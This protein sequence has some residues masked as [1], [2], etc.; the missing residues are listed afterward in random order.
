VTRR[1]LI[2]DD[3]QSIR[4]TLLGHCRRR[5]IEAVAAD[6]AEAALIEIRN[7]EP[8]LVLTDVR[9]ANMDGLA[10][11]GMLRERVPE[12]DVVIMT[13]FEDMPTAVA[14]MKAG[15]LEYLVKPLDLD[16][17]DLV[18]DR[19]FRDRSLRRR[20]EHLTAEAARP[21]TLSS[22]VGRDPA[23][24]EIY[25]RIGT[26]TRSRASVLIRGE[27][28]TGK[29]VIARAIHFNSEDADEPFVAVNCTAVPEGLLES[30]LFGH[31]RGAFTGATADRRGRFE[32]AG[33]GTI[34]LD[35]I[36]DTSLQFQSKLL[37]VLQEREFFAVG[38][39]RPRRTEARV[40][41]ATHR[42]LEGLVRDGRFREDLYY[43]LRVVEISIPPLRER[44]GDIADLAWHLLARAA[45]DLHRDASLSSEA[46]E[47]LVDH[48]WP[49]NV[50]E[51]ENTIVR[52]LAL[53]RGTVIT[54]DDLGLPAPPRGGVP[55]AP[56]GFERSLA[57]V[58]REHILRVLE[59]CGNNKRRACKVLG[60]SRPRLDRLL[61]R[62]EIESGSRDT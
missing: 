34:F 54:E 46:I 38:S 29:E 26:V 6:S 20:M 7:V 36:G 55:P 16:V 45:K 56:S 22:L 57:A 14:A 4:E 18:I 43:R 40:I 19:S 62:H 49:G 59:E 41:A 42:P 3:D 35:E 24:I 31:Q 23:M 1:V 44:R 60:I 37:R 50:R 33:H 28:G 11:L 9:M 17:I 13:A 8:D 53:T 48:D 52:A 21:Y 27:T 61:Q 2:V 51:L 32:L 25:K 47:A 58:E 15:A 39:E 5:G 10:L 30:E 12:V